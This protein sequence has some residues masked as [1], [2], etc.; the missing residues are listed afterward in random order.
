MQPEHRAIWS[1]RAD[2]NQ[3]K[4]AILVGDPR[5]RADPALAGTRQTPVSDA[6]TSQFAC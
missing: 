5:Y 6:G 1:H 3:R 2:F 4:I